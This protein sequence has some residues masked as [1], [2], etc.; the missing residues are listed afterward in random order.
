LAQHVDDPPD[1][2][3]NTDPRLATGEFAEKL[4]EANGNLDATRE[5]QRRQ[6]VGLAKGK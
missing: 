4:D 5:C 6:R 1:I 2:S 3:L